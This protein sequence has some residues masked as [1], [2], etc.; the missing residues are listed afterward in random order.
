MHKK[1]PVLV[2]AVDS[3]TPVRAGALSLEHCIPPPPAAAPQHTKK[4]KKKQTNEEQPKNKKSC[5]R[6][7]MH[8]D[9]RTHS[10]KDTDAATDTAKA[11]ARIR[12]REHAG[13]YWRR[14]Q[15]HSE[16]AR[17]D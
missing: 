17:T 15:A 1:K 16:D 6:Y 5:Q 2:S 3:V 11:K 9:L 8:E 7:V 13:T 4:H 10:D 14:Q 12:I